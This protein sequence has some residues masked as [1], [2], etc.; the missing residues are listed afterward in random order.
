MAKKFQVLRDKMSPAA[1]ARAD[2]LTRALLARMPLQELRQAR[3]LSQEHLATVLGVRQAG[4]SKMERRA[5]MYIS[6]LR[7]FI[8][9]MG[10]D[11]VILAR[12]PDGNV[13][14]TQF[15]DLAAEDERAPDPAARTS[16][17]K[18]TR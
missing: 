13:E 9:A 5:D 7:N 11:L 18:A 15:K 2:E 4:I 8:N 10:G 17:A 1:R 3:H 6:T 16:S 12:F 14:I